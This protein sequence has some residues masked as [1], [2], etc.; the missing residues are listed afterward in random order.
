ML[1]L[2]LS[3]AIV[4]AD[5]VIKLLVRDRFYPGETLP[6]VPGLF[7]LTYV[8]NTGAAW[9]MFGGLNGWLALLSVVMLLLIV[10]FRRSLLSDALSHR[11]ALGLMI[12]GIAGNLLDRMRLCYV[13]DF[14]DFFWRGHHFPAFNVADAAI[15]TGVGLYVAT[16]FGLFA[17]RGAREPAQSPPKEGTSPGPDVPPAMGGTVH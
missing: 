2:L 7:H 14:M 12:G 4:L 11:L 6:V 15:C 13:V 17:P 10:V 8:R 9:G 3:F 16:S 1:P 5:Q